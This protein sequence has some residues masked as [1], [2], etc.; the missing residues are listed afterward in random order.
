VNS[1]GSTDR[2]RY[3]AAAHHFP[4][5]LFDLLVQAIARLF[6]GKRQV[7]GFF[8]GAGVPD[9]VTADLD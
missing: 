9:K 7:V 2:R 4:P 1:V 6:R 3:D 8:Q 5:D